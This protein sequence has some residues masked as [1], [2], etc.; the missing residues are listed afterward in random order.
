[1]SYSMISNF[2]P[3][4]EPKNG[5]IGKANIT[6]AD[7][8]TINNISVFQKEDG[9]RTLS[10]AEFGPEDRRRSYVVPANK[11]VY[12]EMLAVVSMAVDDPNH[13]G[14]VTGDQFGKVNLEVVSGVRVEQP[15][16][17]GFYSVK[18]GDLLT[19]NGIATRMGPGRDGKPHPYVDM[20]V[21]RGADGK[22]SMYVDQDGKN[23][24][25]LQFE[26][27]KHEW[28]DKDGNKHEFNYPQDMRI[29]VYTKRK[30]L[31]QPSLDEKINGAKA[32][33]ENG[34]KTAEAPVKDMER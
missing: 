9:G 34:E 23:R 21:V 19:L 17:D 8:L 29:A 3:A 11:D 27:K 16:A 33:A 22:V 5:Y 6:I 2:H 13:F 20:P 24:A 4:S 15:Y 28:T 30:E 32:Q 12:A 18:F 26:M 14:H 25:N 31:S 10:F 1:M 7:G